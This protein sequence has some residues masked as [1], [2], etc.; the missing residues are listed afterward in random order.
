MDEFTKKRL[1][2]P[3]RGGPISL[4]MS[5]AIKNNSPTSGIPQN[6]ETHPLGMRLGRSQQSVSQKYWRRENK[7]FISNKALLR[8][9]Y[10]E[11]S[12]QPPAHAN[13]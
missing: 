1:L 3:N 2:Y 5:F 9:T 8:L 10:F 11:K 7:C 6:K 4:S 13:N 12:Q